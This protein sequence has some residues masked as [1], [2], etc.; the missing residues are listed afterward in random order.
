ME[1]SDIELTGEQL[2]DMISET[3]EKEYGKIIAKWFEV[4][5]KGN[6]IAACFGIENKTGSFVKVPVELVFDST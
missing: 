6:V 2:I 3:V 4:D 5:D 1:M